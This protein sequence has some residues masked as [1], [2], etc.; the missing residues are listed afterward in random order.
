MGEPEQPVRVWQ[1]T[2]TQNFALLYVVARKFAPTQEFDHD[3]FAQAGAFGL[4]RAVQLR[5][6]D[7]SPKEFTAYAM[8]AI[9]SRIINFIRDREC[10]LHAVSLD[11]KKKDLFRARSYYG[12]VANRTAP[13]PERQL[14]FT[15]LYEHVLV[16]IHQFVAAV[17]TLGFDDKRASIVLHTYGILDESFEVISAPEV[18]KRVGGNRGFPL[19]T[20]IRAW[21]KLADLLPFDR[22]E[23]ESMLELV[24]LL[25]NKLHKRLRLHE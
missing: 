8:R 20:V 18:A 21:K 25:E 7:A 24:P 13:S 22:V 15:L 11:G 1:A 4:M 19:A 23:F 17:F 10:T 9:Q 5:A 14:D 12:V 3:D 16:R 6:P 2:V